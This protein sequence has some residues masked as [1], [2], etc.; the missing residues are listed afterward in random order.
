MSTPRPEKG[1]PFE[2]FVAVLG[3]VEDAHLRVTLRVYWKIFRMGN[4]LLDDPAICPYG[5]ALGR[6]DQGVQFLSDLGLKLSHFIVYGSAPGLVSCRC[7]RLEEICRPADYRVH[8]HVA[9]E[10][11]LVIAGSRHNL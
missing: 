6:F 5:T 4:D 9:Q 10:T 8:T 7:K 1:C 3:R 11:L 2:P